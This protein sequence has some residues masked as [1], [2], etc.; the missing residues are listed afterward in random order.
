LIDIHS[1]Q[2]PVLGS[3]TVAT[4]TAGLTAVLL[5]PQDEAL[6]RLQRRCGNGCRVE[7]SAVGDEALRQ[8]AEYVRSE[9]ARF[10]LPLAPIGTVFQL[11]VWSALAAIPYGE[12]RTYAQQAEAVGR[13]RAVR[14]VGAANGANPL[15]IVLPCHRVVGSG[16]RLTG[17]AYGLPLKAALLELEARAACRLPVV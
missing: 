7:R 5:G 10:D 1:K 13:P 14:A 8:L 9:R 3:V 2:L 12:T 17:Y 4:S 11:E 6:A 16:G 15:C